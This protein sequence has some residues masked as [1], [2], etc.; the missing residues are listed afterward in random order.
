MTKV[1]DASTG[2]FLAGPKPL[3]LDCGGPKSASWVVRCRACSSKLTAK[4]LG[5]YLTGQESVGE[6][7]VN[8][9]GDKV[10]YGALHGWVT[11]ALGKAS[12][13]SIDPNHKAPIYHWGNISGEYRRDLS[14]WRSLCPSCNRTDG[15]ET[16]P[17]FERRVYA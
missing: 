5:K 12:N 7:N 11:R 13:C 16:A 1:R 15:V 10:G 14:D 4:N 9:K 3:C 2:R 17:R 8:W 6:K